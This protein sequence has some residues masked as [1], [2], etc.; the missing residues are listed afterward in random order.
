[1]A[2]PGS[3]SLGASEIFPEHFADVHPLHLGFDER[4]LVP[5]SHVPEVTD[6]KHAVSY[7][8]T[9]PI[10]GNIPD[11]TP[12]LVGTGHGAT[13]QNYRGFADALAG[14]GHVVVVHES[15]KHPGESSLHPSHEVLAVR[16]LRKQT[17]AMDLRSRYGVDVFDQVGHS[18]D[19]AVSLAHAMMHPTVIRN[20][21][22]LDSV[23]LTGHTTPEMANGV[24][25]LLGHEV[26]PAL[27]RKPQSLPNVI[28]QAALDPVWFGRTT[29]AVSRVDARDTYEA[30]LASGAKIETLWGL[31]SSYFPEP[32]RDT[33]AHYIDG[34]H[35]AVHVDPVPVARMVHHILTEMNKSESAIAV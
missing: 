25:R 34:G 4:D 15:H 6:G 21:L 9:S 35:L 11:D 31:R 20:T 16:S 5:V 29:L 14:L 26:L 18:T 19:G 33:H 24:L 2:L 10:D 22:L 3:P 8:V 17:V 28:G 12:I 7:T 30:L 1:M 27:V 23:G 13:I 32:L